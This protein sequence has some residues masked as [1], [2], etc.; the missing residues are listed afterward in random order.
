MSKVKSKNQCD[1][2]NNWFSLKGGNFK[3][4]Y[5]KCT[6]VYT[7]PV[8]GVCKHC[9]EDF[10]EKL[11]TSSGLMA[12]H[13]K[14]CHKNPK[15]EEYLISLAEARKSIDNENTNR[16]VVNEK[17]KLAHARGAYKDASSKGVETK[18]KNGTLGHTEASRNL[19]REKALASNHR[20]L[21]K[22]VFEYNGILLESSWELALAKRLDELDVRWIRPDPIPWVDSEGVIHNYFPDFYLPEYDMY[23]DPKNPQ[24]RKVQKKKL[25]KLLTQYTNIVI[26]LTKK[27]CE[28]FI[29]YR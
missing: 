14:W 20:R 4:H 8:K 15:R 19:I 27:E 7:I 10:S 12:N 3:K 25:E 13:V 23:L 26:I 6:G 5:E 11:L 21:R 24:A 9:S 28:E 18:R 29:P 2:C 22:G 17:I 1:K 16:E